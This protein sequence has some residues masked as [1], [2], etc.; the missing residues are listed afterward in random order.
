MSYN[1]K[2]MRKIMDYI[3]KKK[4]VDVS[5]L[6]KQGFKDIDIERLRH[7]GL[8]YSKRKNTFSITK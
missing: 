1:Q 4:I 5:D 2:Q 7:H 8:I 6:K 3:E